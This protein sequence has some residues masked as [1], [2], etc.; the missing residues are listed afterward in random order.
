MTRRS[1]PFLLGLCAASGACTGLIGG[2]DDEQTEG[3]G[4]TPTSFVCAPD[5]VPASVALRR[6]SNLQYRN[7][8]ADLIR[9]AVPAA[10]DEVLTAVTPLF[11]QLPNDRPIGPDKHYA[12]FTRLDQALQQEHTDGA[13]VVAEAIGKALVATNT[14][15]DEIAGTCATDA[16]PANDATCLDAMI[17][18]LGERALRRTVTDE[19]VAFY[20]GPAGT[21]PFEPADYADVIA[22]ILNA[23]HVLYF[24]E[25]GQAG[26]DVTAPLDGY[27]LASR[28]SYHFWQTTPDEELLAAA[29]S[30]ELITDAGF[31][32]QVERVFTDPR[33]QSSMREFFGQWLSNTTLEELDSRAGT[34]LFDAFADGYAPG[35]DLRE[36]MLDEVTDAALYYTVENPGTFKDLLTSRK[37]F[38]KTNDLASL[39]GVPVWSGGEPSDFVEPERVGLLT[40]AA[41]LA[42]GSANTRP[43]MK[44][45]FIRKALLC[46]NIPPP[47]P[48]AANNPPKLS[49]EQSTRQVVEELT[50]GGACAGCHQTIINALGFATENFD[51]LGRVR[52]E[53][54]LFDEMTG[55]PV[56]TAPVNTVAVPHVESDDDT[57]V[58]NAGDLTDKIVASQKPFACFAKQ[59]FRFTF[60][61]QE[62]IEKDACALSDV[63]LALDE[64]KTMADVLK[65]IAQSTAFRKRSFEE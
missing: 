14:R 31:S 43:I 5:A 46:D 41:Y 52:Q 42:T 56:G 63:K 22:L 48:N 51:S 29:K 2:P 40:R 61:R 45:V 36:H 54:T 64:G 28:I 65:A 37:S 9:F 24:V 7:T 62:N 60:G 12:G 34:P 33:T 3:P 53:Q 58:N 26:T 4:S 47:P 49:Q 20:R 8:M 10:K 18:K 59:Y 6:L 39:Y 16:D 11:N 27:E 55:Q 50:G 32:A 57:A 17:R 25:H 23:P 30:G 21:V 15:L 1:W 13:Y 19:D 35:P 44:G 38:A